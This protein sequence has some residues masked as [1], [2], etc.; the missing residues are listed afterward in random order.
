MLHRIFIFSRR[1]VL[2]NILHMWNKDQGRFSIWNRSIVSVLW[3]IK[4]TRSETETPGSIIPTIRHVID[5]L[6][7]I[8]DAFY[9]S[10]AGKSDTQATT[11]NTSNNDTRHWLRASQRCWSSRLQSVR[12]CF[13]ELLSATMIRRDICAYSWRFVIDLLQEQLHL[14]SCVCGF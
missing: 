5:E 11:T 12:E 2:I 14:L 7:S 8:L 4:R 3:C 9:I 1:S 10:A 13:G 6:L